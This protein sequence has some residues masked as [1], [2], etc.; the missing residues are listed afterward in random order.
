[1]TSPFRV[2]LVGCGGISSNWLRPTLASKQLELVG[3]VDLSTSTAEARAAEFDIDTS[4]VHI[5][6][7]LQTALG[8]TKPDIVF[9]CT[10]PAAHFEVTTAALQAGAHVLS[11]KPLADTMAEAHQMI[12]LAKETGKTLAVMQN[13]RYNP[14]IRAVRKL[15]AGGLIGDITTINA[16]FY[17]GAH[18]GGFRDSMAHVLIKDMAIHTFDAARYLISTRAEAVYCH[19]WNPA[20]SWYERDAS[21]QAI[22]EMTDSVVFNYRG[23]WS[24]EGQ[25]TSW[26]SSWRIVGTKGSLTWDGVTGLSIDVV[27]GTGGFF[28]EF[29]KPDVPALE[30]SDMTRWHGFA[31]D[32]FVDAL[33]AGNTPETHAEDNIHSL[34]MV[35][36]AIESAQQQARVLVDVET[37]T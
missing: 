30:E 11:E 26:D 4:K 1:M 14:S 27:S 32:A 24:S 3:L 2:L 34:A 13:R 17:I 5:G 36:A 28:S 15:L 35:F 7:D 29:S 31:I 12:A 25:H 33:A 22:F 8:T 10:I 18:F 9:N 16:D 19:E 21:A 23:S 37:L 20:G 6:S